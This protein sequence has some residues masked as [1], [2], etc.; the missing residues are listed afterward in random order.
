MTIIKGLNVIGPEDT[1][2]QL[3]ATLSVSDLV[4]IGDYLATG[5]EPYSGKPPPSTLEQLAGAVRRHGRRRGVRSLRS[6]LE[7]VRYGSMSPQETRLRLALVDAGLPEPEPNHRVVDGRGRL[8]ALVDLAYPA[9][10]VAVEYLGDH[11]RTDAEVYHK[12]IARREMLVER[13]WFVILVTAGDRFPF[14][15]DRVRRA[16]LR[17]S[18]G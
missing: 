15:V 10:M 2:A 13:G 3:S 9:H 4:V 17:S 6:A 1:W 5:D 7:Y 11:H 8:L 14:V 12:D 18:P 16:L